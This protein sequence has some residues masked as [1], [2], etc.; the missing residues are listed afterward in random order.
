MVF[1]KPNEEKKVGSRSIEVLGG[2]DAGRER[3]WERRALV[4]RYGAYR[5]DIQRLHKAQFCIVDVETTGTN[6][7]VDGVVEIAALHVT[8]GRRG[9]LF[10]TLVDPRRPIP[11]E[12]TAIHGITHADVAG[13][14]TLSVAGAALRHFVGD[15][16]VVAHYAEF[17][18]KFLPSL[19][20][21]PWLCSKLLA[22]ALWPG[23]PSYANEALRKSF[24]LD[25]EDG[26]LQ[27]VAAHRASADVRVTSG[28]LVA[29]VRAFA[30]KGFPDD[31]EALACMAYAR[32][33]PGRDVGYGR[34]PSGMFAGTAFAEVPA[35]YLEWARETLGFVPDLQRHFVAEL[36]RREHALSRG[37]RARAVLPELKRAAGD[38]LS[39]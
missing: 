13:Q 27:G 30:A 37:G 6:P 9:E 8:G 24:R 4:A 17:D 14:P 5:V 7:P 39:I 38:G 20:D 25:Q 3:L 16:I 15:R 21:R 12:V 35:L 10:S 2:G 22:Q 23:M 36:A 33:Y 26:A 32:P 1:D 31:V 19:A 29:G 11:P 34:V 28:V 18:K